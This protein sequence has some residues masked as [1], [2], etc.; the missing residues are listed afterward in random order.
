MHYNKPALSFEQQ[1]QKLLDRGLQGINKGEL[2]AYLS[3]VNYYRL[4]AYWYPFIN[5]DIINKEETFKDGTTFLSIWRRYAFDRQL[6]LLVMDAIE[7]IEIAILRTK[8]VEVFSTTYGPFG[9]YQIENFRSEFNRQDHCRLILEIESSIERSREEFIK[10]YKH[11]YVNEK[12]FPFWVAVEVTTFGQLFTIFRNL[13]KKEKQEISKVFG[14]LPPVMESWLKTLN[15]VRNCCAHHS[16]LWNRDLPIEPI[17]P[18]KRHCPDFYKPTKIDNKH[19]Y[20]VLL[21]LQYLLNTIN[22]QS[23]W[24][25]KLAGLLDLYKD[26]PMLSMGFPEDWKMC[27]IW[28]F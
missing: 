28:G 25:N 12:N 17:I 27:P 21:L 13:N 22:I 16:R 26:I 3:I 20:S 11:E 10:K 18:D 7:Y 23:D 19:I 4:S 5:R 8:M 6:R 2:T 9:F 24:Q 15:Y 14:L 1:A